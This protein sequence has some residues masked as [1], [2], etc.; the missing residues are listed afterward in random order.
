MIESIPCRAI[1]YF[2]VVHA[3]DVESLDLD[4]ESTPAILGV[5]APF[6]TLARAQIVVTATPGGA[7]G[8]R[9]AGG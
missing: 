7:T 3:L 9:A 4:P 1:V 2:I 5:T 6:H 8:L